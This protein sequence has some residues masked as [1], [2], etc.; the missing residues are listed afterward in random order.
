[1]GQGDA[2]DRR[3]RRGPQ[4]L[5]RLHHR[6]AVDRSRI[7]RIRLDVV[8]VSLARIDQVGGEMY[9][10]A[11]VFAHAVGDDASALDVDQVRH[12]RI[13]LAGLEGAVADAVQD[14]AET[15]RA[16]QLANAAP[17]FGVL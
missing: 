7:D 15:M 4:Q 8:A 5:F 13:Q 14:G 16:K 9:E 2:Q 1:N 12:G 6:F 17:V 11:A 3:L 10:P